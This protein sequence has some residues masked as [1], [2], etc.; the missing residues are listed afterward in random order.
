MSETISTLSLLIVFQTVFYDILS[1][2]VNTFV[3]KEIYGKQ[4]PT[5]RGI[6][7]RELI[8]ITIKTSFL[9]F[10]YL[11]LFYL[12]IPESISILK[13]SSFSLWDFD[14]RNTLFVF[15]EIYLFVFTALSFELMFELEKRIKDFLNKK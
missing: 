9:F 15:I 4:T 8:R 14:I 11:I 1:K 2:D 5:S 7:R 12:L 3:E 13:T 6:Y 10:S